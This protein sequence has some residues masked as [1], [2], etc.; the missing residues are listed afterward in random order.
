MRA[1]LIQHGCEANWEVLPAD[2]E[3]AVKSELNKKAHSAVILCLGNKSVREVTG[4]T[5]AVGVW[6]KLE[7]LYM[8]K[9]LANK[10]Y[11]KKKLYT[12]YML[13]GQKISKHID[14]FNKIVLDLANI[15]ALEIESLK[16]RVNKLE[17]KQRSRTPKLKR[18]FKVGRSAQVISFEDEDVFNGEEVI[19]GQDVVEKEV[20][21]AD[22]V[23]TA[24]EVVTT[25]SVEVSVATTTTTTAITE[26]DLTS[27]QALAK[28]RSVKPK[29][30]VQEPVQS[31][32]TTAPLTIPKA[33]SI[34]FRDPGEST[35]RPT[36]TPIPSNIKD[37]GKAKMIEPEKP[38]KKTEQIRLDEELAFKL[39][40]KEKEQARLAREKAEEVKEANIPWDNV[41]AMIEADRLLAER[42]QVR[43]QE[44]LTDEDKAILFVELLEK[45]KKHFAALRAQ[46]KRNKPPT[47][48]QNKSTMS[49]YLKHMA[50]YKQSQLKNE[51]FAEIQNSKKAEAEMA[52]E[53]SS[54][55]AGEEI[56]QEVAKKQKMEDDKEKEDLKQLYAIVQDDEVA[57]DAIPLATKPVPFVNFQ[58]HKKGRN[59]YYEIM[60]VDGSDKTYLLFSQLLKEF[61]KEDLENLWKLVKAKH[62]NTRP[63]EGYERVLW[64]DLKTIF[65]HHIEDLIWR[66]LQ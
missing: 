17:K 1:L 16:R 59:G 36:L 57:I 62:G 42:L 45:R 41:Q 60:R 3:A 5:T 20:S 58:I 12:F 64:G 39:K 55:R 15:K 47:K 56:E 23:T 31:I 34:T 40:A 9:S 35:T 22:P 33:K 29:V 66:N 10:L 30:V 2:M 32:T 26:V 7:T 51:S 50:G 25:V 14:E 37:K 28:L 43:E 53:S 63:E 21:T 24:G 18:L 4:E 27:A 49:T 38:L 52:Q 44:E 6:S 54:K 11:L 19:A 13:A 48:A 8:T 46:E 61:D 65:E